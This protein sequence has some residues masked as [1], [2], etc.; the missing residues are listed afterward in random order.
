M[1]KIYVITGASSEL[2]IECLKREEQK[3]SESEQSLAFCQYFSNKDK[4]LELSQELKHIKL[5][6]TQCDLT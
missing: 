2:A 3:L 5:E 6:L 1:Q 4:I